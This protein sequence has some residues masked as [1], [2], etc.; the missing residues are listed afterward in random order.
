MIRPFLLLSL[1]L[2]PLARFAGIEPI[3]AVPADVRDQGII[4]GFNG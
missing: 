4:P 3:A 1:L 2:G